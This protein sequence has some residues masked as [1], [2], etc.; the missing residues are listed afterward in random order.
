MIHHELPGVED[1]MSSGI[2]E[3]F[4]SVDDFLPPVWRQVVIDLLLNVRVA[5]VFITN[6]QELENMKGLIVFDSDG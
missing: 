3:I 1:V 5:F 2:S 6:F 4:H